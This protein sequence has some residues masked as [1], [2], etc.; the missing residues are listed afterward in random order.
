MIKFFRK[1]RQRLLTENKF[2]RYLIYA[3]GEIILVVFGIL[4]ALS[5]NNWNE[6]KK[7]LLAEKSIYIKLVRDLSQEELIIQRDI[8]WSKAY[9]DIHYQVYNETQGAKPLDSL[10]EYNWLQYIHIYHPIIGAQYKE[11]IVTLK[12]ENI[13]ALLRDYIYQENQTEDAVIEFND[14][15]TQVLR[16]FF[17]E[18]GIYD[19]DEIYH[20]EDRYG[21]D[22]L[23][24]VPL[25]KYDKLKEQYANIELEEYLFNLRFKTSW[26]IRNLELLLSNNEKLKA[27]LLAEIENM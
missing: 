20:T 24:K 12:N 23:E 2:S 21:F 25:L 10:I 13:Q 11:S 4:I 17:G 26:L 3:I 15:K 18:Y 7:S 27:I 9:Q 22:F 5:V 1:I 19:T 6:N 16:P 8:K 14:F